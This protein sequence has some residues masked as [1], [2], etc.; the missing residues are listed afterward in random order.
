MD[1]I[2]ID[3]YDCIH[4]EHAGVKRHWVTTPLGYI[5]ENTH[6]YM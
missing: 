5:L 3:L 2:C 6:I 1:V 4:T